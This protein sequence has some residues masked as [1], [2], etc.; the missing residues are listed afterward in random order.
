MPDHWEPTALQ[1]MYFLGFQ[2]LYVYSN[3]TAV[4]PF[5]NL[6]CLYYSDNRAHF[7]NDENPQRAANILKWNILK[8]TVHPEKTYILLTFK[9]TCFDLQPRSQ[10]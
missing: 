6:R 3:K 7:F 1:Q 9:P 10:L 2:V 4:N 8:L 5:L